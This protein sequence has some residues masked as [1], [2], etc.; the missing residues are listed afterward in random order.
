MFLENSLFIFQA[1]MLG[2]WGL[3]WFST[4]AI[5][6]YDKFSGLKQHILIMVQVCRLEV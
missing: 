3:H 2:K 4:A 1:G 5:T 6:D